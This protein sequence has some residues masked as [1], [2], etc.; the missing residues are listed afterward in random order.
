MRKALVAAVS[1][2]LLASMANTASAAGAFGQDNKAPKNTATPELPKCDR[3]LGTAA[4]Q[5]PEN[6]WWVGLG[7]SS[8]ESLLKLFAARSGCLRIVDRNGGLAMRN[9]EKG[10]GESGDLRRGSNIGKGQVA[11]ADFF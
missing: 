8:P 3:A 11:S 2:G 6:R 10:L 5:E 1:L 4:V 9:T 7:L